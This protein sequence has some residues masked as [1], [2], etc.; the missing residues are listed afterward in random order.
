M[1]RASKLP[2]IPRF[3]TR[4]ATY[5]LTTAYSHYWMT[6]QLK[7]FYDEGLGRW[8]QYDMKRRG[9]FASN[10]DWDNQGMKIEE[11]LHFW[12]GNEI[13]LG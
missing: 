13:V 5:D 4:D 6:G 11:K 9:P 10:T 12:S 1:E 8:Q 3:T 2:V 7:L